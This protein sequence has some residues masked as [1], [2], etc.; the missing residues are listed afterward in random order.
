MCTIDIDPK[1]L[2]PASMTDLEAQLAELKSELE[3]AQEE[4][5]LEE[6]R[7]MLARDEGD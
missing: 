5:A 4:A 2:L 7:R 6:M 3:A 1:L